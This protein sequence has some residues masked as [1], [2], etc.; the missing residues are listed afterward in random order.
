M[1][2]NSKDIEIFKKGRDKEGDNKIMDWF[3]KEKSRNDKKDD[4]VDWIQGNDG[5]F[6]KNVNG[7]FTGEVSSEYENFKNERG[8]R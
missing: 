4:H 7:I 3:A 8:E 6:R 5:L 2:V 1:Q